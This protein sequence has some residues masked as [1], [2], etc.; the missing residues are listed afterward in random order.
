[1]E[2]VESQAQGSPRQGSTTPE[3]ASPVRATSSAADGTT[4]TGKESGAKPTEVTSTEFNWGVGTGAFE[5]FSV[6]KVYFLYWE[7]KNTIL[8]CWGWKK[9]KSMNILAKKSMCPIGFCTSPNPPMNI[10]RSL[11]YW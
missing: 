4:K 8:S 10:D 9:L 3:T 2:G 1:M 6:K 7:K 11:S 5:I